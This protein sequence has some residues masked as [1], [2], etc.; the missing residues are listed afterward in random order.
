[1]CR[2]GFQWLHH[3]LHTSRG[4]RN[5]MNEITIR[6]WGS[7]WG[8]DR[9]HKLMSWLQAGNEVPPRVFLHTLNKPN[10]PLNEHCPPGVAIDSELVLPIT[11]PNVESP[12]INDLL[13]VPHQSGGNLYTNR[14]HNT[15]TYSDISIHQVNKLNSYF[16]SHATCIIMKC[17]KRRKTHTYRIQTVMDLFLFTWCHIC[18]PKW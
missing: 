14:S 16:L 5:G 6:H 9:I 15:I 4:W 1:M 2:I 10:G 3:C 7:R 11:W 8:R 13:N 12:G 17:W 18:R